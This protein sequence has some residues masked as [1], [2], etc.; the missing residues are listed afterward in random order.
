MVESAEKLALD[1]MRMDPS[2]QAGG[3]DDLAGYGERDRITR[4]EQ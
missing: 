3:Y 2:S 1:F 4:A